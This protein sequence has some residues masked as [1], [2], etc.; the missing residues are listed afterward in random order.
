M[1]AISSCDELLRILVVDLEQRARKVVVAVGRLRGDEPTEVGSVGGHVA[2]VLDL[3]LRRRPAPPQ[4]EPIASPRAQPLPVLARHAHE[5]ED[6]RLRERLGEPGDDVERP[7]DVDLVEKLGDGLPDAGLE[8]RHA[9]RR[10]GASRG[11]AKPRVGGRIEADH[12]GLRLVATLEQDLLRLGDQWDERELGGGGGE[13]VRI[14]EDRL[15]VGVPGDDVVVQRRCVED[16]RQAGHRGEGIREEVRR[17]RIEAL[18]NRRGRRRC[19]GGAGHTRSP[20]RRS[21]P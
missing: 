21:R 2:G 13:G 1:E 5:A 17:E 19:R 10:Q 9:L 15:D 20:T 3:L 6:D 8:L 12:R 18:D 4:R 7:P 16:R 14:E 11:R